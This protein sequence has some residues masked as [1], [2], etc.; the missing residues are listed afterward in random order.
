M[1]C[2][3]IVRSTGR[4]TSPC[5]LRTLL[6][7]PRVDNYISIIFFFHLS[8]PLQSN[9]AHSA[10]R[11]STGPAMASNFPPVAFSMAHANKEIASVP[12]S[13][14]H[15]LGYHPAPP[16]GPTVPPSKPFMPPSNN[17]VAP[18]HEG[19]GGTHGYTFEGGGGD[20]K[21]HRREPQPARVSIPAS[22]LTPARTGVS[23]T[24]KLLSQPWTVFLLV[25]LAVYGQYRMN[26]MF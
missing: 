10:L 3:T 12:R 23:Y 9:Y 2:P 13:A 7:F 8:F 19:V 15:S 17:A 16:Q 11:P 26:L 14:P 22:A 20:S 5:T 18:M 4:D 6:S 1:C 24:H 21:Q 25:A